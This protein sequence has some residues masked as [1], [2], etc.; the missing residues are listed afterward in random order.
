MT[1]RRLLTF[2]AIA[3]AATALGWALMAGLSRVLTT[4]VPDELPP[5]GQTAAAPPAPGDPSAVPRIKAT[6]FFGSGDGHQLVGVEHEVPLGDS[7][8]A[9]ARAI[10][11]AQLA[12]A[13]PDGLAR[14]I[15]EGTALRG[16]Y[17]SER[18]EVFIDLDGAIRAA[19]PGGSMNELVTVYTLVDA[20][21]VNLPTVTDV[22]ILIDGREVDTLAGHVDLRRPL[23]KNEELIAR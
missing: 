10:L 7:V 19:H 5:E 11:E 6:L 18:G 23:Q 4:T 3:V 9:Q 16:V 21:T 12:T 15:P 13:P 2:V 20:V 17:A 8:V 1:T 22:Q 14:T